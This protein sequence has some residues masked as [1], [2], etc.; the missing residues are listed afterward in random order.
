[1]KR[2]GQYGADRITNL[3]ADVIQRILV[4]LPIKDAAKT[5][6]L[7]SK[8]RHLWRSIPQLVF[9][10]RFCRNGDVGFD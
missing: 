3:P 6:I 8:W 9:D 2:A 7:T 10:K 5:S 1:M 4:F